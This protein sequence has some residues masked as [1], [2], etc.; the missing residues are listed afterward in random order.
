MEFST[1]TLYIVA[2]GLSISLSLVLMA[3]AR[4]QPGTRVTGSCAVAI[5][6]LSA[7]LLAS[8]IGPA[9][10]RWMTVIVA[11]MVLIAAGVILHS[12]F[13]AFCKQRDVSFDRSGWGLV[14]LT[15]L[16]FWY[17]GLIE[18][19][20][21]Y[22]SA[23]F[24]LAVAAINVRTAFLL[25]RTALQPPG[26]A[27]VRVMAI[28]FGILVAWMA[29]RGVLAIAAEPPAVTLRGA[30]PTTWITV[31]WYIVLIASMT[32]CIIWM[33]SDRL[34]VRRRDSSSDVGSIGF[35][36]YFRNRLLLL[37]AAVIILMVGI[38]GEAGVVYAKLYASEKARL[39]H[40]TEL[41]NEAFVEHTVQVANQVDTILHAVRAHYLRTRSVAETQDFIESLRFDRSFIDNI[42][43]IAPD[44]RIVI[45]HDPAAKGRSVA[46]REYFSFHQSSGDDR[47]SIS[48]VESGRVT[49]KLH[50]RITRRISNPDGTFGGLV[51]AAVNPESFARYYRTL[52]TGPQSVAA[53]VGIADR[54]LR[55]RV[56][57]PPF[58]RWK[59]PLESPIW[60]ALEKSPSGLYESAS[61][62]DGIRRISAYRKVGQLPLVMVTGFSEEDV[63]QSVR[64]RMVWLAAVVITVLGAA[65]VLAALLTIEI[66]RRDDQDRF[67]SMLSHELKTPMSVIRMT[68][69]I[70]GIPAAIKERVVRSVSDMNA[71]L[72]RCLQSDRL[73]HGRVNPLPVS[74]RIEE[75]LDQLLVASA[76]PQRLA[77]HAG[78]LPACTTDSQ[79][80]GIILGNLFDNAIKYGAR[81]GKVTVVATSAQHKGKPGIRIEVTNAAGAAGMPDAKK[82]FRKFYRA[83][84]A[85]GKSGSGLGLYIAAGLA[86]KIGGRLRYQPGADEVK[87][88]LWIPL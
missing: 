24:S 77:V 85:R 74:C 15:A 29:A 49:A 54:K 34:N 71:I 48:P 11:N 30:N 10:P 75:I 7:G 68:L 61:P 18:P 37:W 52:A 80:V 88:E 13:A 40:V 46:D 19:N 59:M 79:L 47:L 58:D 62:V 66:R 86:A 35:I 21:N 51:L 2:A 73:R 55:A 38:V 22:R 20:G 14:A 64:E 17:W 60:D 12:G 6:V 83:A 41:A 69:G 36:D 65:F 50:F 56:P 16:P 1:L 67:M 82:V 53:L 63:T 32:A 9:L 3:F 45:S 5:L 23:V 76:A 57:E 81:D 28:L 43:L 42:Y 87:F 26:S 70:E 39:I 44:G 33:E 84:G 4:F 8:G 27:P 25:G 72:E 78:N 31:F